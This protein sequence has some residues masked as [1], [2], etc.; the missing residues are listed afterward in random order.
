MSIENTRLNGLMP[1][2]LVVFRVR[3]SGATDTKDSRLHLMSLNG[4][5]SYTIHNNGDDLDLRSAV[6]KLQDVGYES[7]GQFEYKGDWFLTVEK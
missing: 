2:K 1:P 7:T 6:K 5:E 4:K 3:W